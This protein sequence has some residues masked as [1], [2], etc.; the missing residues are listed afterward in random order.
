MGKASRRKKNRNLT[1]GAVLDA[2][3]SYDW[4]NCD[5][6]EIRGDTVMVWRRHTK[7]IAF[8]WPVPAWQIAKLHQLSP[9]ETEG[10]FKSSMSGRL[11]R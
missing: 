10:L 4:E 1:A 2:V 11:E 5:V 8:V 9:S 3:D 6:L 7:Q